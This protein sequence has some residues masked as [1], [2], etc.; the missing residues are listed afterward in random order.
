MIDPSRG[1]GK[2]AVASK[3]EY[4]VL[5][6]LA[7]H[8]YLVPRDPTKNETEHKPQWWPRPTGTTTMNVSLMATYGQT[9][10]SQSHAIDTPNSDEKNHHKRC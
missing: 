4:L 3:N 6:D 1:W 2:G 8:E 7:N 9:A 5:R 10:E